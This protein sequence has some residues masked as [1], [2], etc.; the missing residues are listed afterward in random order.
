MTWT[1]HKKEL[2]GIYIESFISNTTVHTYLSL[3]ILLLVG[4]HIRIEA[5]FN[6]IYFY[7]PGKTF[8]RNLREKKGALR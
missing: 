7:L 6:N 3:Q 2:A 4:T 8:L 5:P 1:S